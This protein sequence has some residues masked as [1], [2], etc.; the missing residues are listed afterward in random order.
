MQ[1]CNMFKIYV[2]IPPF[3]VKHEENEDR[4]ELDKALRGKNTQLV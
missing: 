1:N 2:F 4:D 3:P